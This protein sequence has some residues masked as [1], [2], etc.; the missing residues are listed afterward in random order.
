MQAVVEHILC[1][2]QG[3]VLPEELH[4]SPLDERGLQQTTS[5]LSLDCISTM[6]VTAGRVN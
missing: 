4:I 1:S 2:S 6:V 3:L 5:G